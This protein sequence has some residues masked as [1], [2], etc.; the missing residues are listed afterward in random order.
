MSYLPQTRRSALSEYN[1]PHALSP[2]VLSSITTYLSDATKLTTHGARAT[3][4]LPLQ[5]PCPRKYARLL[6]PI[7][8]RREPF[9]NGQILLYCADYWRRVIR[10]WRN[11]W[12]SQPPSYRVATGFYIFPRVHSTTTQSPIDLIPQRYQT[13]YLTQCIPIIL[14]SH[15]GHLQVI[16]NRAMG[17][18]KSIMTS[19]VRLRPSQTCQ[20][21]KPFARNILNCT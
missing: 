9:P 5:I 1:K 4:P 18:F 20:W 7:G 6:V 19:P 11:R 2:K 12:M 14:T 13:R 15:Y 10:D 21:L 8:Q 3:H 17:S 16:P